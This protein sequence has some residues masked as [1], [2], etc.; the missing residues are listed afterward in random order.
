M[1][2]GRTSSRLGLLFHFGFGADFLSSQR[3]LSSQCCA[4]SYF[5]WLKAVCKRTVACFMAPHHFAKVH[6]AYSLPQDVRMLCK[7]KNNDPYKASCL[8]CLFTE[9][10][11]ARMVFP[12]GRILKDQHFSIGDFD[13]IKSNRSAYE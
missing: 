7:C 2:K 10:K 6:P 11:Y 5:R 4:P 13:P 8:R 12:R 1:T 9:N 3:R